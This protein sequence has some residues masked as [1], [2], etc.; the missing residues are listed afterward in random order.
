MKMFFGTFSISPKGDHLH[1]RSQY[2]RACQRCHLLPLRKELAKLPTLRSPGESQQAKPISQRL[3]RL[4][5]PRRRSAGSSN[6]RIVAD[7]GPIAETFSLSS[8]KVEPN[9]LDSLRLASQ[10]FLQAQSKIRSIG[11]ICKH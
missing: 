2:F 4:S 8:E 10:R 5:G 6:G 7:F 3:R 1:C 11:S 9:N